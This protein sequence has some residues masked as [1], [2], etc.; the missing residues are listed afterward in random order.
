MHFASHITQDHKQRRGDHHGHHMGNLRPHIAVQHQK[1]M[2]PH[3]RTTNSEG[4][5]INIGN[6]IAHEATEN[7]RTF[8]QKNLSH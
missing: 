7:N 3:I 6:Q 8:Y 2:H 1:V 5:P 4:S